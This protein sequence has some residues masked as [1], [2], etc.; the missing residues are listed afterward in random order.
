M[1]S[2]MPILLRRW[3][4]SCLS[5]FISEPLTVHLMAVIEEHSM[6]AG[7]AHGN[8]GVL[9]DIEFK[10]TS[11]APALRYWDETRQVYYTSAP[12]LRLVQP[13]PTFTSEL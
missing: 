12:H 4:K 10:F 8:N 2:S 1:P 3:K 11:D 7:Q 9:V 13:F 5:L 6:T